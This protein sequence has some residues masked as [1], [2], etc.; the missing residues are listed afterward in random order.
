M[1]GRSHWRRLGGKL[2]GWEKEQQ[3]HG[4]I[5]WTRRAAH[6]EAGCGGDEFDVGEGSCGDERAR[7]QRSHQRR[8]REQDGILRA[9]GVEKQRVRQQQQRKQHE[10]RAGAETE[11]E[12]GE[13]DSGPGGEEPGQVEAREDGEIEAFTQT[14]AGYG[15]QVKQRWIDCRVAEGN[16]DGAVLPA[17]ARDGQRM[18]RHGPVAAIVEV[19]AAALP[20]GANDFD[21][22]HDVQ[23]A[24]VDLGA[25]LVRTHLGDELAMAERDGAAGLVGLVGHEEGRGEDRDQAGDDECQN[26]VDLREPAIGSG[27]QSQSCAV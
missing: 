21:A 2:N 10:A 24:N 3:R 16:E 26:E 17:Q 20:A 15:G 11:G 7:E 23:S 12:P 19:G 6:G 18:E 9:A 1:A 5:R 4:D 27:K 14:P 8:D 25:G 13:R 22:F